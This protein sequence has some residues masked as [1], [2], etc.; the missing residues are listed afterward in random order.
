[1]HLFAWLCVKQIA[2]LYTNWYWSNKQENLGSK[3]LLLKHHIS[4]QN[5]RKHVL[6]P[7]ISQNFLG[8]MS[9]EPTPSKVTPA[10]SQMMAPPSKISLSASKSTW[11]LCNWISAMIIS[12][13]RNRPGQQK[14]CLQVFYFYKIKLAR[15]TKVKSSVGW[16]ITERWVLM[17][18]DSHLCLTS[19]INPKGDPSFSCLV[20]SCTSIQACKLVS[21]VI[22]SKCVA[23]VVTKIHAILSPVDL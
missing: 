10:A 22:N 3:Q 1:M 6:A 14:N 20:Y 19:Y 11:E 12:S 7:S 2:R 8:S 17:S 13:P 4:A 16:V 5:E 18:F 15:F 21:H 9:Q 23:V